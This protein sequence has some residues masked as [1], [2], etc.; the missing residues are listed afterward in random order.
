MAWLNAVNGDALPW[1]LEPDTANP[2]MRYFA[3]RD[4]LDQPAA[5]AEVVAAQAAV[6]RSGPVHWSA[7]AECDRI[8][9]HGTHPEWIG[10]QEAVSPR[11]AVTCRS[12]SV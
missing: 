7:Y 1:L 8:R 10:R 6:M 5:A 12:A 2:G 9:S 4:L 11:R 3:L